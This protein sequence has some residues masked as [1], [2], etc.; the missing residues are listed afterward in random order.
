MTLA[1]LLSLLALLALLVPAATGFAQ[2]TGRGRVTG[3]VTD[4]ATAAPIAGAVVSI[5]QVEATTGDD[6]RFELSG[7]ERGFVDVVV[8]AD[9]YEVGLTSLRLDARPRAIA[10][11]LIPSASAEIVEIV[12]RAP[13][14]AEPDTYALTG[15]E[16]RTLPGSG[17]DALK[18][19]QSLPGVSRV[20]FG[21]GGLALRGASPRDSSV[22]LDGIEVPLLYHFGGLA[23]FYPSAHLDDIDLQAG[24]FGA[25][26]GRA[27]GGVVVLTSRP[28]RA[29]RWRVGSEVSLIDASLRAEGPAPG[30]G[31]V[32]IGLRRSYVDAVLAAALPDGEGAL[33]LTPRYW[34]GQLRYDRGTPTR[35][36]LTGMLFFSDDALRFAAAREPGD[37][38]MDSDGLRYISRFARAAVR[39]Q[40]RAGATDVAVQPWVGLGEVAI[41]VDDEGTSRRYLP[42][43]LRADATRTIG[44]HEVAGGLDL[45]GGRA[46]LVARG[47]PAPGPGVA[48]GDEMVI[49]RSTTQWDADLGW[50]T[51]AK[52]R[53]GPGVIA[54]G[55][56]LERY[57]LSGEWVLDPRIAY[58]QALTDTLTMRA[59]LGRYHQPPSFADVDPVYGNRTATSS[60]ADQASLGVEVTLPADATVA[61]TAFSAHSQDLLVDVVSSATPAASGGTSDSGGIGAISGELAED[62]FGAYEYRENVGRGR[63]RGLEVLVRRGGPRWSGWLSYTWSRSER[64][65][66][67][68]RSVGWRPYLLDQPHVLT[69]LGVTA[70]GAWRLGARV[71]YASGNP[72]HA[73]GRHA[74]RHRRPGLPARRR[75]GAVGAPARVLPARP[76]RRSHVDATVGHGEAV[77]RRPERDQQPQPRGRLLQLRLHR[78]QLHPR[79]AGVPLARRGVRAVRWAAPTALALAAIGC[80]DDGPAPSTRIDA[81]RLLAIAADPPVVGPAGATALR[82]LVVDGDGA[83]VDAATARVTMRACSPWRPVQDPARDCG[84]DASLPLPLDGDRAR[85]EVAAV[86]ARFPPPPGL[87]LPDA[88]GDGADAPCPLAYDHL[89]LPVVVEAVVADGAGGAVR[90]TA[91][92]HVRLTWSDD[93]VRTNPRIDALL[94]D[95]APA[96]D[97]AVGA[98]VRLAVR[99][100]R[101]ALDRACDGDDPPALVLEPVRINLYATAG[102]L[103]DATVDA[104]H[105]AADV[106]QLETTRFLP[107]APGLI[108]LWAIATDDDGGAGWARFELRA[109]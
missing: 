34:D 68:V 83:Q 12:G 15:D 86:I 84:P 32:T 105:D 66:D 49:A 17:N 14:E 43:G 10:I 65:G 18:A 46:A 20:P 81:P 79:P 71:R 38:A 62:Q 39:Y 30:Q 42:V 96:G 1:R 22:F 98:E 69:A 97:L 35:G 108:V 103:G 44:R 87:P 64:T 29:D 33:T 59:A 40:R 73:G 8:L 7:T 21:L 93:V 48:A 11:A 26:W 80:A 67:P 51:E 91:R 63:S 75:R 45:Q 37:A 25:R 53:V 106:E 56:R 102:D 109:R 31:A 101:D 55:L 13:L 6:G 57:G 74:L 90:L 72:L 100:A 50:W 85:L 41:E 52:L 54:P 77:P 76:A 5:G 94:V 9:G 19:L 78:A 92:K 70:L 16:V 47:K 27:Q 60:S 104:R 3:V 23:S 4:A 107:L 95:G 88:G 99:P 58:A 89:D 36:L 28:G 82:A 2:G 24:S 61:V